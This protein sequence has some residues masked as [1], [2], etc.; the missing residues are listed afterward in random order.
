LLG[1]PGSQTGSHR[2]QHLRRR[3][4]DVDRRGFRQDDH[5]RI[6][7]GELGRVDP[8]QCREFGEVGERQQF[9]ADFARRSAG[10]QLDLQRLRSHRRRD[11]RRPFGRQTACR[12]QALQS[13][14]RAL[15]DLAN[16]LQIEQVEAPLQLDQAPTDLAFVDIDRRHRDGPR[17]EQMIEL[18][19][20][21]V[22]AQGQP[23][24]IDRRKSR[25]LRCREV[26]A[27]LHLIEPLALARGQRESQRSDQR[28]DQDGGDDGNAALSLRRRTGRAHGRK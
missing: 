22:V 12:Q 28:G 19:A 5:Q 9:M 6:E 21:H 10:L 24:Q 1:F 18:R 8:G 27:V 17:F 13:G 3:E 7:R 25:R 2:H 20:A 4:V 11:L 15:V 14:Q 23:R 26:V 16:A